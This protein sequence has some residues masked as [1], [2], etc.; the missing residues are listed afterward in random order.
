MQ[1]PKKILDIGCGKKKYPGSIGIDLNPKSDADIIK[2]VEKGLPFKKNEFDLV[3]SSHTLEHLDPKKLVFVLEE[4]WRVTRPNGQIKITVPHFSGV[5]AASN[6]THLRS[7][8]TSQTFHFFNYED[9]YQKYGRINFEIIKVTLTKGRTRN[10]FINLV[11]SII[12][13]LA[14][15]NPFFC[16]SSWVYWFGGFHEIEFTLRPI[17]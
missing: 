13:Y 7:G 17:K 1:K 5:G 16:E 11:L 3:Y 9:E 8:F 2:N 15:L 14:N 6:P 4:I 12:D 10:I